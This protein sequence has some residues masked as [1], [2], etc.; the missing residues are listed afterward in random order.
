M[1]PPPP[2]DAME[3]P[4]FVSTEYGLEQN[5][6]N[7]FNPVTTLRYALP[8]DGLV[9]LRIF[10]ILGQEVALVVNEY[11]EAGV[12]TATWD[13]STVPS[14]VYFYKITAGSYSE[15][16]KMLLIR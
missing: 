15:T 12:H 13:A 4:V 9:Q 7:P 3:S 11:R 16:R 10:N 6:P 14:G 5:Y 1:P 2:G 8:N